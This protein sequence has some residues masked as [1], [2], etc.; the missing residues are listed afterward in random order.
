[1]EILQIDGDR[2]ILSLS[3]VDVE[4]YR[5][6]V[7]RKE[8]LA[9]IMSD[10]R[11]K[12][13]FDGTCGRVRVEMYESKKGGCELFLTRLGDRRTKGE[14]TL[15]YR[16]NENNLC[17]YRKYINREEREIYVFP[18]VNDLL[19]AC[20]LL[21]KSGYTG[22]SEVYA[23]TD[24]HKTY[25]ILDMQ[26]AYPSEALGSLCPSSIENYVLEHCKKLYGD[27]AVKI[28]SELA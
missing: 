18:S 6:A 28:L 8:S 25:L 9:L 17:E 10:L 4:K 16:T 26:S 13:G 20:S 23:D 14:S 21:E 19:F 5:F 7:R 22:R 24:S 11:D 2:F 27:H 1:M 15:T 12:Y 3:A